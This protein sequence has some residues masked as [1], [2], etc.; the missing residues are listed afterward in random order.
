MFPIIF[1][2]LTLAASAT[3]AEPPKAIM[4]AWLEMNHASIRMSDPA[5]AD[6]QAFV[7][8]IAPN[9]DLHVQTSI[10]SDGKITRGELLL[11]ADGVLLTHNM[12]LTRR[13]EIDAIDVPVLTLQL[14]NKLLAAGTGKK[15]SALRGKS[16]V[17]LTEKSWGLNVGTISAGAEY[18]APWQLKGSIEASRTHV[19]SFDLLHSFEVD[20]TAQAVHYVGNWERSSAPFVVDDAMSLSGWHVFRLGPVSSSNGVAAIVDY[21]ASEVVKSSKTLG[22]LRK[23]VRQENSE[24]I[25]PNQ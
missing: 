8:D 7:Y 23:G 21:A 10:V 3:A 5:S 20:G 15:P 13:E 9:Q 2:L 22:E 6:S 24:Q 1:A 11:L 25:K 19:I 16:T 17:D 14:V 4:T 12:P 18:P